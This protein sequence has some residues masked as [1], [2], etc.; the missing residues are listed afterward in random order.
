MQDRHNPE[1]DRVPLIAREAE[2]SEQLENA[3]GQAFCRLTALAGMLARLQELARSRDPE[4][5]EAAVPDA[6]TVCRDAQNLLRYFDS[7]QW[8]PVRVA[9]NGMRRVQ[10][11][12][13]Q[14]SGVAVGG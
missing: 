7:R 6:M 12:A 5:V 10:P 13:W 8:D 1:A 11:R 3:A 2:G 4:A 9:A 14:D